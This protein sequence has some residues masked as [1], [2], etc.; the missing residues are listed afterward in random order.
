MDQGEQARAALGGAPLLRAGT[1][2]ALL[3]AAVIALFVT[4]YFAIGH[5]IAPESAHDLTSAWDRR[6][7]FVDWTVWIYL[8]LFPAS[9]LPLFVVRCPRLF[10]RTIVAYALVIAASLAVFAAYP[11][12]SAHLRESAGPL[13]TSRLSPWAV[14]T[15]Y[16]L[17]PPVNLFPSL[18]LS[19]ALLAALS[20]WIASRVY[21]AAIGAGVVLV[22]ISI[23]TVK[24]HVLADAAGALVVAG[25]AYVAVLRTYRPAPGVVPAY[26]WRGPAAY[27]GLTLAVYAGFVAAF[28]LRS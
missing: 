21:G 3:S 24:Q 4:G 12:T 27:A 7:P 6:I 23:L 15:I 18:H 28:L 1:E 8:W 13:D 2:R 19:I 16:R 11:V 22:A 26:G 5:A 10:R 17:D 9:L 25:L 14:A 20:A